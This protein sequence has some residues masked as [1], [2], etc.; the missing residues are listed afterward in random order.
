[1]AY[2]LA[3]FITHAQAGDA[4]AITNVSSNTN[5][6]IK[7]GN[8]VLELSVDLMT[9]T[10]SGGVKTI[11]HTD[12]RSLDLGTLFSAEQCLNSDTL[13]E[14]ISNGLITADAGTVALSLVP[15]T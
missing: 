2:T 12:N 3:Q 14:A 11:V 8:R 9:W 6:V 13:K 15:S 5:V 1:M 7:I 10:I 4:V